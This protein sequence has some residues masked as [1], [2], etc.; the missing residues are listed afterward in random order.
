MGTIPRAVRRA[1]VAGTAVIVML[2]LVAGAAFIVKRAQANTGTLYVGASVGTGASCASPGYT[3]VQAAVD[4]ALNGQTVYLC[5]AH[6]IYYGPVVVANKHITLS[7]DKGV[8]LASPATWTAIPLSRLPSQFTHDSLFVPQ[9]ILTIWGTAANV[10]VSNL[11]IA[12]VL[13]GNGG[14]AEQ[15]FG[16]TVIAGATATISHDSVVDIRDVNSG[17]W[18]CQFGVAILVG[19]Y[20]WPNTSF[21]F[22]IEDFVGHAYIADSTVTGYDKGGIVVDGTG[23]TATVS[24]NTVTGFGR[25]RLMAPNN[26]QNGIQVSRGAT[27]AVNHNVVS[28]NDYTGLNYAASSGI[29]LYGGCGDPHVRNVTVDDNTLTDNDVGIFLVDYNDSCTGAPT[30]VSNNRAEHNHIYNSKKTNV[31]YFLVYYTFGYSTYDGYQAGIDDVG[32][33]DQI[34]QNSILGPGYV[35]E[36]RPGHEWTLPIDTLSF[37]TINP[38]IKDNTIV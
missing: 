2:G 20:Y 14:C 17:L 16:V 26:A 35:P 38:I 22:L 5:G 6:A 31:A 24:D 34:I 9:T 10:Y 21:N 36:T 4:A 11:R 19:R 30:T 29:I 32:N 3:N 12:G 15:E 23:T 7:G 33:S 27:G 18:G 28:L 1:I 25:D 8:T 13:P 37:P